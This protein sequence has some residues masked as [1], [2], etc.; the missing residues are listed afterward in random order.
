M[1]SDLN[2]WLLLATSVL[3]FWQLPE[4]MRPGFLALISFVYLV[5][6][7]PVSILVLLVWTLAFYFFSPMTRQPSARLILPI[8]ILLVLGYLVY[9]KYV[10]RLLAVFADEPA[11]Q[12]IIIPIGISYFTFKLIHYAIEI[13]RENIREH[14]LKDFLCY[15]FLLPIFTA[16]PIERFDHFLN[17]RESSWSMESTI[18]GLTRILHGLIKKFAIANMLLLPLFGGVS[19]GA[20]LLERLS[21]LPTYKVWGFCVLTFLYMYLDFSA[22]SDIAIGSSR[23][24][25]LRIMENFNWPILAKN[26]SIFWKRWHMTLASWCQRYIYLPVIGLTRNPYVATYLTF[27]AI[28]LWHSG[29]MG[30]LLWGLYHATGISLFGWWNRYCR[31]RKWKGLDKPVLQWLG[32]VFTFLFVS[33]GSLLTS[34]DGIAGP[35]EMARLYTKLFFINLPA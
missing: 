25:G 22:Y 33:A 28:G 4:W 30:W 26:I 29:S 8:L 15:I 12:K 5:S 14:G 20:I 13:H 2:F 32:I 1:L 23:L 17:N 11:L 24:F 31:K 10:P 21:E 27:C 18:V 34:L 6:L 19:D 3:V 7:E 16:G 35:W 9:F